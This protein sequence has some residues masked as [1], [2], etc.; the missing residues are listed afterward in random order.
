M[1][2]LYLLTFLNILKF[3]QGTINE[4]ASEKLDKVFPW[5]K[6]KNYAYNNII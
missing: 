2:V 6:N 1:K 5:T 3:Y 4:N